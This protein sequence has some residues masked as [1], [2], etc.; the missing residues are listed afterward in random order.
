MD[1]FFVYIMANKSRST[2]YIGV[3]N[4]LTKRVI[5]HRSETSNGYTKKYHCNRLVYFEQFTHPSDA[6]SR[7]KQLKNWRR[8]KKDALILSTNLCMEDL[9]VSVLGLEPPPA[10]FWEIR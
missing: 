7:E 6:I 10:T 5:Q 8:E 4:N 1:S 9:S 2:L 3:T